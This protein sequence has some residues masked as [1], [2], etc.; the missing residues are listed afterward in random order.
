MQ[1]LRTPSNKETSPRTS[2]LSGA[3]FN[4]PLLL[5]YLLTFAV[6]MAA[7]LIHNFVEKNTMSMYFADSRHYLESCAAMATIFMNLKEGI[8]NLDPI[9]HN[10]IFLQDG[11]GIPTLFGLFF[12]SFNHIPESRDWR[13]IAVVLGALHAFSALIL[14]SLSNRLTGNLK[15]SFTAALFWAVYPGAIIGA[16]RLMTE[17]LACLFVVSMIWLLYECRNKPILAPLCGF[18]MGSA[19]VLKVVLI[20]P[21]I[22]LIAYAGAAR[23]VRWKPLLVMTVLT[24][25][26]VAPWA[27]FSKVYFG[28]IHLTTIRAAT[29]NAFIGW[30]TECD[31]W[32]GAFPTRK[33]KLFLKDD[34]ISAIIGQIIV[35][36]Q[37]VGVLFLEKFSRYFGIP[38]NDFR[39]SVYGIDAFGLVYVHQFYVLLGTLGLFLYI[40]GGFRRLSSEGRYLGNLILVMF[41]TEQCYFIFEANTRYALAAMPLLVL[42]AAFG[43]YRVFV[44]EETGGERLRKTIPTL[45]AGLVAGLLIVNSESIVK[46]NEMKEI[47]HNLSP[48]EAIE[49][50]IDFS[51][52]KVFEGAGETMVLVDGDYGLEK[53]MIEVNGHRLQSEV[54][55]LNYY[56]SKRYRQFNLMKEYG[57]HLNVPLEDFRMWRAC[58]VP[59]EFLNLSGK[60]SIKIIARDKFKIYGNEDKDTRRVLSTDVVCVNRLLNSLG[61]EA[62]PFDPVPSARVSARSYFIHRPSGAETVGDRPSRLGASNESVK[63]EL[64]D[65]V[66]IH[67]ARFPQPEEKSRGQSAFPGEPF[68][69]KL[70]QK[71][72]HWL[73]RV[74][75]SD[76]IRIGKYITN[77]TIATTTV[78]L[79]SYPNAS[80][81]KVC[82]S[83]DVKGWE[84]A[85]KIGI[86][87]T[88]G[89]PDNEQFLLARQPFWLP[90][91]ADWERFE[92]RDI[93]PIDVLEKRISTI[94]IGIYPGPWPEVAG[95]GTDHTN[96]NSLLRD[97]RITVE[98]IVWPDVR[99]RSIRIY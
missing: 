50:V 26:M 81:M 63:E 64:S 74:H 11:P 82:I 24:L 57:Y 4:L 30:D 33:E 54:L 21:V 22:A 8:I 62:R 75:G 92:I 86:V 9:A 46:W 29:H 15:I 38:F 17:T 12:A 78:A 37:G 45:I 98:P 6:A 90:V 94:S 99:D 84:R 95:Y 77:S 34:P 69:R 60:N 68:Q 16:S 97:L 36:P 18:V 35:D 20:P 28:E 31:G 96:T 80:H 5:A 88:V 59:I 44:V 48:G 58:P 1:T 42:M 7:C 19:W 71:D 87:S 56:D 89:N 49:K 61:V 14:L 91:K 67:I 93:V 73:M 23:R 53:A 52:C 10:K 55:P 40:F 27:I 66:R 13:I 83:G 2:A 85:G 70:K 76:E 47:A 3:S 39:H 41:L 65:G 43:A 32:Q 79:P 51:S 72:F 25:A